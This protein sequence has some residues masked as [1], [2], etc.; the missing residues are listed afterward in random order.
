VA[1]GEI[2]NVEGGM[3]HCK[4]I[5]AGEV[6]VH[7][8]GSHIPAYILYKAVDMDNSE[9]TKMGAAVGHIVL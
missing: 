1:D 9:V 4:P 5:C 2:M 8:T 6:S 7:V 3:L